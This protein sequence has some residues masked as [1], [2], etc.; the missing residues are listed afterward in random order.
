MEAGTIN[1][2]QHPGTHDARA[3][4]PA[5][6]DG[7]AGRHVLRH[8]AA[9]PGLRR[10]LSARP[11]PRLR[12]LLRPAGGRL[13]RRG[14]G[15]RPDSR[16]SHRRRPA[17]AVALQAAAARRQRAAARPGRRLDAAAARRAPRRRARPRQPLHQ[18]RL[19]QPHLLVQGPRRG[20]RRQP[21]ARAG[22][23]HHRLRLHRQPGLAPSPPPRPWP[24]CA[25]TSSCPRVWR[26]ARS[27]T[28]ASTAPT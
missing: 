15:P 16:E 26:R 20:R 24:G 14:A 6:L 4:R 2:H 28:P 19:R 12:A 17:H 3:D 9:L 27:S 22:H 10:R 18:E 23:R 5:A 13:R 11:R 21:R 8:G 1:G 25:A 7:H